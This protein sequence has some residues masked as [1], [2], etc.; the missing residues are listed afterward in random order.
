MI[1]DDEWWENETNARLA[2]N[3]KLTCLRQADKY[4]LKAIGEDSW[5]RKLQFIGLALE[6]I[7]DVVDN[8]PAPRIDQKVEQ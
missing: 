7:D 1:V 5:H 6:K 2:N 4:L 8:W 3:R